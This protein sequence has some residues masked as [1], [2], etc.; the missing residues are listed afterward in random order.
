MKKYNMNAICARANQL[1]KTGLDKSTV[2]KTAWAEEKQEILKTGMID[3]MNGKE[4]VEVNG[5]KVKYI[6]VV[7]QILDTPNFK[8]EQYD[9]YKMYLKENESKRFTIS[10]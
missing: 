5:Y 1:I 6:T 10:A 9:L 3:C 8:K 2:F 7:R 4:E